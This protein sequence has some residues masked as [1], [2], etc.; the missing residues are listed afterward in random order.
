MVILPA[1]DAVM[2]FRQELDHG[3]FAGI[4]GA[5]YEIDIPKEVFQNI[6][7]DGNTHIIKDL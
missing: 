7:V 3:G 4:G 6:T 1:A 5:V 2:L